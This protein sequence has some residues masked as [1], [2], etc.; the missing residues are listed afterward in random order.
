MAANAPL[1]TKPGTT[2]GVKTARN[3]PVVVRLGRVPTSGMAASVRLAVKPVTRD[4]T[5]LKIARSVPAVVRL[6]LSSAVQ[7]QVAVL[8]FI[9]T[10]PALV[11]WRQGRR[12][13]CIKW[14]G[15]LL[16][17]MSQPWSELWGRAGAYRRLKSCSFCINRSKLWEALIVATFIGVLPRSIATGRSA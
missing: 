16:E 8:Y 11:A 10:A 4:T 9:S 5:G 12:T 2:T 3:V 1:A 7:G 14:L 15:L 13:N 17:I 6:P